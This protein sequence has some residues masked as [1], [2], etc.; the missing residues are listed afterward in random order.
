M[1]IFTIGDI[2]G[3]SVQVIGFNISELLYAI[4]Q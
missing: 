2:Q 3:Y 1:G 4:S